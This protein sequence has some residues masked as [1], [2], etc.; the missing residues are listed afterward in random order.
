MKFFTYKKFHQTV[1]GKITIAL[2]SFFL[3][4]SLLL[5]PWGNLALKPLIEERLTALSGTEITVRELNLGHN[6][7]HLVCTDTASNTLSAHGGFSLLTLRMYGHYDLL[8]TNASGVN[9]LPFGWK[10]SG[11]LSGG[12]TAFDIIGRAMLG[13]GEIHYR[14]ELHRFKLSIIDLKM[15]AVA[16]SPFIRLMHYP[17]DNDAAL[18]G[19]LHLSGIDKRDITGQ[20]S[21]KTRT[22]RFTPTPILPDDS[23]ESFRLTKFLADKNGVVAP[24]KMDL[25]ADIFLDEAG[26]IEQFTGIPLHGEADLAGFIRG[27]EKHLTLH[28]H[29]T[30]S[31]SNTNGTLM[32]DNLEPSHLKLH[33]QDADIGAL[34]HFLTR[35]APLEGKLKADADLTPK[36]G[37]ITLSLANAVTVPKVL[38]EDY[39]LTQPTTR[40]NASL[41]ANL[42]DTEVHYKGLFTSDLTRME[43]DNTTTHDQMLRE[44]L[45]SLR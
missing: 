9:P 21:L 40:V 24:F 29:T 1:G 4:A 25:T 18:Y 37:V 2:L 19:K 5:T 41:S 36:G 44:L 34:F 16:L 31:H 23:N 15:D 26:V 30:L 45:R 14:L 35:K 22:G 28:A 33:A 20:L 6:K 32:I 3:A 11:A 42:S 7:F 17:S 27:D 39:N 43:I 38:K 12:I 10:T 8:F 13:R